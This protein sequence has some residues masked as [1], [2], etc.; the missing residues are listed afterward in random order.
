MPSTITTAQ[1]RI[2]CPTQRLP[3]ALL[4][5]PSDYSKINF[6]YLTYYLYRCVRD[7]IENQDNGQGLKG[8][9]KG[10]L[11]TQDR[12]AKLTRQDAATSDRRYNRDNT[13]FC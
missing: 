3:S 8:A 10:Q 1:K 7:S 5:L 12:R 2:C 4:P 11:Y 9:D 13:S 6:R